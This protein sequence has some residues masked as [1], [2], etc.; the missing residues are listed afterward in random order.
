MGGKQCKLLFCPKDFRRTLITVCYIGLPVNH[1]ATQTQTS[2][3][4]TLGPFRITNEPNMHVFGT[5]AG[6]PGKLNIRRPQAQTAFL[7]PAA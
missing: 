7:G 1:R 2:H 6:V 3:T 5:V 4:L